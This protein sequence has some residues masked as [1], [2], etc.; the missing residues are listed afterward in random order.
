MPAMFS[1]GKVSHLWRNT[2]SCGNNLDVEGTLL[3]INQYDNGI[4]DT[5]TYHDVVK[6]V[7]R[8]FIGYYAIN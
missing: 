7:K 8:N 3:N 5:L 6:V 2:L 4:I 1:D